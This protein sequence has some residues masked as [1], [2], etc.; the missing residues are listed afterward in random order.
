MRL[1]ISNAVPLILA[2][3][4]TVLGCSGSSPTSPDGPL[5][6]TG[7]VSFD[8]DSFHDLEMFDDGLLTVTLLDLR[9]LIFD[10]SQGSPA[11]LVLGFGLGQRDEEGECNLT[12]NILLAEGQARVYRLSRD[13]YCIN[14]FDPGALPE[15]ALIGYDLEA[16]ISS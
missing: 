11:N 6:F 5:I 4:L 7:T 15:D 13:S 2:A 10:I 16:A 14:I 8:G 9:V 3:A 12:T 1:T